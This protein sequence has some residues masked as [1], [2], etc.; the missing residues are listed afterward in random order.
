MPNEVYVVPNEVTFFFVSPDNFVQYR[1]LQWSTF[2]HPRKFLFLFTIFF[3][4]AYF[5]SIIALNIL[6][7]AFVIR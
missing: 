1:Y 2:R 7:L 3:S 6:I 4:Y 5:V